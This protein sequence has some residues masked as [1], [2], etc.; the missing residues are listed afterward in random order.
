MDAS[1]YAG[2]ETSSRYDSLLAKLIVQTPSSGYSDC[3]GKML[4]SLKEFRVEG[5]TTN[6]PFLIQL[7][8]RTDV[9]QNDVHTASI[10]DWVSSGDFRET[11]KNATLPHEEQFFSS[12]QREESSSNLS[13]TPVDKINMEGLDCVG[14][15]MQGT[16]ISVDVRE[17]S[18][19][20]AGQ[21]LAL[22]EAMKMEHVI[23]APQAG[24]IR[25]VLCETGTSVRE[26]MSLFFFEPS[27]DGND[28]ELSAAPEVDL[29]YIRPD[30]QEVLNRHALRDDASRVESTLKRHK[31]GRRTA[32]ENLMD[33]VDPDSFSEYG[34]LAIAAQR[35]RRSLDDLI[36]NTPAD[37][38]VCGVGT[39]NADMFAQSPSCMRT[40][41]VVVSYDYMVLAGTQ[42]VQNHRKK[43]RMFEL[44][45]SMKL[46][47]ILFAEGGG[48]IYHD[49]HQYNVL[50]NICFDR[51][52]TSW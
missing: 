30:L 7:L 31:L 21:Q 18:H 44:A 41:C 27:S 50:T 48:H 24:I 36:N 32:R 34:G 13:S 5:V 19:V 17:G 22:M 23:L 42:G 37:G 6:I 20:C 38:M 33:L 1:A 29:D 16:L 49:I 43:D 10:Q 26:G 3:V 15:P 52:R 47:V 4:R 25:Q 39:V 35:R 11:P 12:S 45:E 40:S 2:Y 9:L 8:S 14:A 46:P 28:V 51:R